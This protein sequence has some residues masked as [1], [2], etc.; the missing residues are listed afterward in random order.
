MFYVLHVCLTLGGQE[1]MVPLTCVTVEN[2][3]L[4]KFGCYWLLEFN[5]LHK[6]CYVVCVEEQR[7]M[8]KE[9]CLH[10]APNL[11]TSSVKINILLW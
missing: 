3:W 9:L 1:M 5:K 6:I 8:Q 2:H 4:C 7:R 10:I 11:V